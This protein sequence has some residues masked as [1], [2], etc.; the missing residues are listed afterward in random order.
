MSIPSS[1]PRRLSYLSV[2][3][4]LFLIVVGVL[5]SLVVGGICIVWA[6]WDGLF[7]WSQSLGDQFSANGKEGR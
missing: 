2:L 3:V 5:F 6:E 1:R 7:E 4:V